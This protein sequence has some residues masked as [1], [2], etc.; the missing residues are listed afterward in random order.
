MLTNVYIQNRYNYF[1]ILC[2]AD[3]RTNREYLC[4]QPVA[5]GTSVKNFTGQSESLRD[6]LGD[7]NVLIVSA[8]LPI[9]NWTD[10]GHV[11][12]RCKLGLIQGEFHV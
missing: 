6:I 2:T 11:F 4:V 8:G 3:S 5:F 9:A 10:R 1:P 7:A 12:S